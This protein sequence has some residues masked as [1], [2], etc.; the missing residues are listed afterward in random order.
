ME[1]S[2]APTSAPPK[3]R[4]EPHCPNSRLKD[5]TM[6]GKLSRQKRPFILSLDPILAYTLGQYRFALRSKIIRSTP[7]EKESHLAIRVLQPA[8]RPGFHPLFSRG[9]SGYARARGADTVF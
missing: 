8:H 6:W 4:W 2:P 3:R 9:L 7:Y 5:R 1:L